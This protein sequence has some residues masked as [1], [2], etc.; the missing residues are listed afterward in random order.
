MSKEQKAQP[1]PSPHAGSEQKSAVVDAAVA[2]VGNG[3][4]AAV[5]AVV[6]AKI[7]KK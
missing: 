1:I 4:G 2:I 6:A 5:G 7:G 3:V